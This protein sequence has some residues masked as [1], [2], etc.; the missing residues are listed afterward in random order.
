MSNINIKF[1]LQSREK[2][3]LDSESFVVTWQLCE[4]LS[5]VYDKIEDAWQR[6]AHRPG[7]TFY[8][9]RNSGFKQLRGRATKYRK[10]GVEL[11]KLS[12]EATAG[13]SA[14]RVDYKHLAALARRLNEVSRHKTSKF[15]TS[16]E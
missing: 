15:G 1:R 3:S 9:S 14:Y 13:H 5:E 12:G 10:K 4:S 16:F 6:Q 2:A 7:K 11:K 8:S